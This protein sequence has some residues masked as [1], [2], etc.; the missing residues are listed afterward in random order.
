MF[1]SGFKTLVE[2]QRE[3]SLVGISSGYLSGDAFRASYRA[4][5]A[6]IV[7]LTKSVALAGI[8]H[9]IR[10]NAIAPM[11]NTRMTLASDLHFDSDPEDIAPVAVYLL[12]DNSRG[13]NGEILSVSGNTLGTWRDPEPARTARNQQRW[14]QEDIG[15]VVPWLIGRTAQEGAP[16]LPDTWREAS[17]GTT[18]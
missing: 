9:G 6:G 1:Q 5:K 14:R 8:P 12:S 3:G 2:Q 17:S 13:V 11:A 4:A 10:V 7:A 16:P 18:S 15:A